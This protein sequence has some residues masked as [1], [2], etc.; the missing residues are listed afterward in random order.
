MDRTAPRQRP[1]SAEAASAAG[2]DSSLESLWPDASN[3]QLPAPPARWTPWQ[4]RAALGLTLLGCVVLFVLLR[5]LASEPHIAASWRAASA[6]GVEL[7]ASAHPALQPRIG[8]RLLAIERAD[9]KRIDASVALLQ[10]APRW[11]VDDAVRER[12][13]GL[14]DEVGRAVRQPTVRLLFDDRSVVEVQ[15]IARGFAG[16]G[17]MFW[18]LCALALVLYLVALAVALANPAPINLLYAAVAL[19]QSVNLVLIATESLLGMGVA[20]GFARLV[21][22]L[23]TLCDLSAAAAVLHGCA[24]YPRRLPHGGWIAGAGWI[25]A[26]LAGAAAVLYRVPGLWWW[27]QGLL[28]G[29]GLATVVMLT[30][31]Y[32]SVPHPFASALRRLGLATN[33]TLILLTLAIALASREAL[34]QLTIATIGSV[35]WYVFFASLLLL[36]P[37]L[38]RSQHL[39]R[40]FALLAGVSTVATSLDL[41]FFAV[42]ALG[43]FESLTL[44]LLASL[45]LY[46]GARQ[47][48]LDQLAGSHDLS[49]ERMFEGLY[50][51]VRELELAPR[52]VAE[53][54]SRL[55]R[56]LFEPL[57]LAHTPRQ[58]SRS[59]VANDGSTL[60][61]PIPHLPG[62]GDDEGSPGAIVLRFARHG[63]H[64][65]TREDARLT[66]RVLEQLRRAVAYEHAVEQGRTEERTRIAQ[67]LHDDIGARLLTLMYK[68][69]NPEIEDYI[70]HTLQDLKTLTRGLAA[71]NHLL[72]HAAG[73]WKADLAQRLS[74][75]HCDLDWSLSV[76]RD[77]ALTVVQWSALTRVLRELVNNIIAHAQATQVEIAAQL[78]R[79][80]LIVT[81]SDDG[82]GRQPETWS[83]GLGL[84]GVRKRVKLLGGE[85]VWRERD[86]QGIACEVR[87]AGLGGQR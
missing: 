74:L 28:V 16:L 1:A 38:A 33:G 5:L 67:D 32:R 58:L 21:L 80:H 31:A 39:L 82:I 11:I 79:E 76:D 29:Y 13:L 53:Q 19:S 77:I 4:R 24:A 85:V 3:A 55:L 59:R 18:L 42:F 15:P 45:G 69:P 78:E 30:W 66:D 17:A 68:A 73:E 8:S 46:A 36:V 48:L 61:V 10:R 41:L 27:T 9:G 7:V 56:E 6:G 60:V 23:R 87:V 70:R 65:F 84:G 72:S 37:F 71:S 12:Q 34:A 47:W 49:A 62:A 14:Q 64:L 44:S 51:V 2:P 83:H 63:R 43:P 50:R 52:T 26:L 81:I 22:D 25:V 57:E 86:P 54:L 75:A 20:P 40:E 35:V